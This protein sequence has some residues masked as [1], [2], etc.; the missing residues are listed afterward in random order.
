MGADTFVGHPGD[1]ASPVFYFYFLRRWGGGLSANDAQQEANARM[2]RL[3]GLAQ[4]VNPFQVDLD[5][6]VFLDTKAVLHGDGGIHV[7]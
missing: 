4:L 6:D 5:D 2:A 7:R 1:S 3:L